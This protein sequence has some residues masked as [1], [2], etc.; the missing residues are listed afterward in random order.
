MIISENY[1]LGGLPQTGLY[2]RITIFEDGIN[3]QELVADLAISGRVGSNATLT[4]ATSDLPTLAVNDLKY[5][6]GALNGGNN[7]LWKITE[8]ITA[9]DEVTATKMDGLTP[10]NESAFAAIISDM[11]VED[12]MTEYGN[13]LY[14]YNFMRYDQKKRYL[15][16]IDA[17][18]LSG[19]ERYKTQDIGYHPI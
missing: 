9:G 17:K 7:G 15:V 11:P 4:S 14:Y 2:P 18:A 5:V 8:I 3:S 16:M 13:G 12:E 1:T 6:N 19:L 10:G